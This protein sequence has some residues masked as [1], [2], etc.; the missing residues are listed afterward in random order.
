VVLNTQVEKEAEYRRML[1]KAAAMGDQHAQEELEREYHVRIW[2]K[3]DRNRKI[4]PRR[5]R[6]EKRP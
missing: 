5:N 3:K 2:C 1:F 4:K 6:D